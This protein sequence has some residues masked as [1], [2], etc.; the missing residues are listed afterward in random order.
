MYV[1]VVTMAR[2]SEATVVTEE[3]FLH[4]IVERQWHAECTTIGA[5]LPHLW[6][7]CRGLKDATHATEVL[8]MSICSAERSQDR[9][10]GSRHDHCPHLGDDFCSSVCAAME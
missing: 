5:Y 9:A 1:K 3:C 7:C 8:R 4:R 2:E 6:H 10:V